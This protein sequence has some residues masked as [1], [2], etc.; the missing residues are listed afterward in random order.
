MT[1]G[2]TILSLLYKHNISQKQLAID[3]DIAPST[4][5]GYINNRREPDYD[6][7][8]KF[9]RYF[10]VSCDYLLNNFSLEFA[11]DT[12]ACPLVL[13]KQMI[14]LLNYFNSLSANQQELIMAQMQLMQKQNLQN[15]PDE[16]ENDDDT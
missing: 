3:L 8:L 2:N 7:L 11:D 13:D 16:K 14:K 9:A 5:N 10:H 1:I 12:D 15:N 6:T 4:L